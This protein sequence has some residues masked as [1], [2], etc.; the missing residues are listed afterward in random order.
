LPRRWLAHPKGGCL[1][2]AGH[3]ERA[4]AC[5]Y[6]GPRKNAQIGIFDA[7]IGQLLRGLPIGAAMEYFNQRYAALA[8]LLTGKLMKHAL[9]DVPLQPENLWE[10]A[11]LWTEHNDARSY[12]I[13]GDPATRLRT[14]L[15]EGAP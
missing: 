11:S 7:A 9:Y 8:T 4:W 12:V 15:A 14:P 1:A 10:T 13:L 5:S 3:V 2:V 6:V